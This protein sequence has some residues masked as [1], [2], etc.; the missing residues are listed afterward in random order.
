[1]AASQR[2]AVWSAL[3]VTTLRPSGLKAADKTLAVWRARGRLRRQGG[4]WSTARCSASWAMTWAGSFWRSVVS[5]ASTRQQQGAAAGRI[6]VPGQL[7]EGKGGQPARH[8]YA[9]VAFGACHGLFQLGFARPALRLFR[10]APGGRGGQQVVLRLAPA[11]G[12]V[13]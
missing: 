3:A 13:V 6:L 2:R 7:G 5:T 4:A 10:L 1:M 9:A 11:A 12:M 8:G